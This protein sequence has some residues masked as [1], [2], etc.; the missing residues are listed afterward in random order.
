MITVTN[1]LREY[2]SGLYDT[3]SAQECIRLTKNFVN[4]LGLTNITFAYT[5]QPEPDKSKLAR[6]IRF[7]TTPANWE[8]RYREMNY[9]NECPIYRASLRVGALPLIWQEV[10]DRIE[11][12]PRQK[13]M[14][15]EAEGLGLSQG[16]VVPIKQINGDLCGVGLSTDIGPEEAKKIIEHNLPHI[17]LMSHHLH[18]F[19]T[20]RYIHPVAPG[21][22]P[23]LTSRE[24][25][26]LYWVS[27]GKGTWEISEIYSISENTVKFHLRNV[28]QK[29]DVGTRAAAVAKAFRL[30]LLDL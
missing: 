19:M 2:V 16:V 17:F 21:P 22:R 28:L 5:Q 12:T 10:W 6:Y 7:S 24:Q 23:R 1:N 15:D 4:E 30:G 18:A 20:D 8:Q 13:Q 3:A 14:V 9:Q 11:K 27:E 29:L 25:N 26:C